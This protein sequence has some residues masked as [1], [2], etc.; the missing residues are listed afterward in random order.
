MAQRAKLSLKKKSP[1][2]SETIAKPKPTLV[3]E[4]TYPDKA[5]C[6]SD[7]VIR[8]NEYWHTFEAIQQDLPLQ[9][10]VSKIL[11]DARPEDVTSRSLQLVLTFYISRKVYLEALAAGGNRYTLEGEVKEPISEEHQNSGAKNLKNF[12]RFNKSRMCHTRR[13]VRQY[14]HLL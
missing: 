1:E 13:V 9:L 8:A 7:E 11:F 12:K 5:D 4:L 14:W 2:P 10:G 6:L 3:P